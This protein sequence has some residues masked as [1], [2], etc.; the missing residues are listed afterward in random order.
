MQSILIT[1]ASTGIGRHTA[2]AL[3]KRGY[4]VFACARKET[5]LQAL[6]EAGCEAIPLDINNPLSI[7]QTVDSVLEKTGGTLD[8]LFNNAGILLAG[9]IEDLDS[10]KIRAQFE[11][12][13]FGP[14][15][16]I[17]RIL[18]IMRK[19][20]HGRIVQNSSIL[21]IVCVPLTGAYNASKFALE[22]FSNTL[23]LELRNSPIRLSIINPGPIKSQLRQNAHVWHQQ[24]MA[25]KEHSHFSAEYK[26]MEQAYFHPS[27]FDSL[28]MLSPEA[29]CQKVI[30][31]LE[32]KRPREHYYIGW[33]AHLFAFLRRIL[34]ERMLDAILARTR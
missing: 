34:P 28:L 2:I 19:Q 16:L 12:N 21:G 17:Q 24:N 27:K 20:G 32:S 11:T 26:K 7:Q 29:V 13:V 14:M 1:G 3:Q 23:R 9:A 8:A 30:H 4:R 18:P 25:T 22:G 15:T 33:P 31:A 10:D 6:R 5:D